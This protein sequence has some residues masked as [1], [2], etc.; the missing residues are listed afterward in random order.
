MTVLAIND[1]RRIDAA[2]VVEVQA[3]R[4]VNDR[5][6]RRSRPI[7]A[8]AVETAIVVVAQTQKRIPYT[9]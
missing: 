8:V 6:S 7:V 2:S 9:F 3:V 4:E 5:R 1:F